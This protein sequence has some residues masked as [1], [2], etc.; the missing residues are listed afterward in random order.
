ME[1]GLSDSNGLH[2]PDLVVKGFR[3]IEDLEIS[4]LGRVN[5]ISGKNSV[6]K[7][8]LLDAV[9]VYAA[10]GDYSVLPDIL[11]T[12]EELI[13]A[14]DEDGDEILTPDMDSLFYG[15]G[16]LPDTYISIGP[17]DDNLQLDME[18]ALLSESYL[19]QQE[20][21]PREHLL[22][23][24]LRVLKVKFQNAV[25]EIPIN[26]FLLISR[27]PRQ[28]SKK[29]PRSTRS[30]ESELPP[31]ILCETLGP[32]LLGNAD[33]ARFWDRVALTGDEDRAVDAL[34]L[35]FDDR[36]ERVAIVGND[37]VLGG[38]YGDI[39]RV[40]G[41]RRVV[42]RFRTEDYPV[43]LRSLGD[44]A[45][46]LFSTALALANSRGGFLLIDEVENGIHYSLAARLL[47][48]GHAD[49]VCEQRAGIRHHA[50]LGLRSRLRISGI[51]VG[52]CGRSARSASTEQRA[53]PG[54]RI[55]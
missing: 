2:L 17:T 34:N 9:R 45:V 16:A 10:R 23:E 13:S 40:V 8:S 35:I 25:Q 6:G 31:G 3:G 15:R 12:R 50:Q 51:R 37:G 48:D 21:F 53:A 18:I 38:F 22:A 14:T 42:A 49:G 27:L 33:M 52:G 44:G 4:R 26:R 19:G 55:L 39:P 54:G 1:T 46:R 7:T 29:L 36:V 11:R 30:V 47:E 32:G 28:N 5:L 43:P 24:D 20:L 41:G